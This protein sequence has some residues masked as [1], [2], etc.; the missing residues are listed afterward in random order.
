MYDPNNDVA[1]DFR[2]N[3]DGK[4][5]FEINDIWRAGFDAERTTDKTYL[6]EYG[7]K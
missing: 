3:L 6:R 4:G 7:F 1:G 5:R 2:G